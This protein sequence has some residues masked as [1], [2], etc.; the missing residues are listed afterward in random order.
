MEVIPK[1]KKVFAPNEEVNMRDATSNRLS[2]DFSTDADDHFK[3]YDV[4]NCKRRR[5]NLDGIKQKTAR[6]GRVLQWGRIA[7]ASLDR[8]KH[9]VDIFWNHYYTMNAP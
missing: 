8:R 6:W 9:P 5:L 3:P 1:F 2:D 4:A 7:L